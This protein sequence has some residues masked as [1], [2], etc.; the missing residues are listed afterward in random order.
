MKIVRK[1]I[2]ELVDI[3]VL[4]QGI[5]TEWKFSSFFRKK[6]DGGIR[7]VSDLGKLNDA[8]E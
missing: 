6:K 2:D 8:L 3:D 5:D 4:V 1:K 7:F